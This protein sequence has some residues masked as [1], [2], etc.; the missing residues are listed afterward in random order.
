MKNLISKEL[1]LALHPTNIIFLAFGIM[2][3]IPSY[4]YYVA[5]FYV[6][7]GIFF[8]FL[9]GRENN[10]V[11]FTTTLPVKKSDVV[12]ARCI[13]V[14]LIET[15]TIIISVPFAFL[16]VAINPNAAGNEA[17]IEANVAFFGFVFIMFAIF[18]VI[19]IPKFYKTTLKL[20]MPFVLSSTAMVIFIGVAEVFTNAVFK[21]F[22]DTTE[23]DIMIKQI[24]ILVAGIAIFLILTF[25]A[26]K[27]ASK[28]FE[29]VDL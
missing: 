28:R 23:S 26:Y 12:K 9:N 16:G 27:L 10:D 3:L 21:D 22:L 2:L 7:L 5:F 20:G 15:V 19:F 14:A 8:L 11:F 18:N 6:C 29:E 24:P 4:P 17:G 25:A 13:T 1:K